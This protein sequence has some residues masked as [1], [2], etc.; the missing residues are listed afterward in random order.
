MAHLTAWGILTPKMHALCVDALAKGYAVRRD[1]ANS[2][3]IGKRS[4][5]TAVVIWQTGGG[6]FYQATRAD[7]GDL[8][9]CTAIR[10]LKVVRKILGLGDGG[11]DE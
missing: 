2:L 3:F 5:G 7:T 6:G 11:G 8:S 4:P 1:G 9:V 10:T